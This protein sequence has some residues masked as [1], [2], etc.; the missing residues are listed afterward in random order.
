MTLHRCAERMVRNAISIAGNDQN[1][2]KRD[3]ELV[4]DLYRKI[5]IKDVNRLLYD[6]HATDEER[7]VGKWWSELAP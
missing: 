6:L 2:D 7:G 1:R 5:A 3:R 4:D